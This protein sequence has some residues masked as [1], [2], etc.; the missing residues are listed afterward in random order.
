MIVKVCGM[1]DAD[2]IRQVAQ[3]GIHMMGFIFYQK[4]PRCVSRPVSRCEADAGV[5]RIGVFVNDSVMHILQCINDYNLNGVQ[6]HGQETPEFGRQLKANGV[7]LLLKA[8]S[9]A[10]VNDLKQCGAYDGIVDYFVFDTKTPDYGGSGKCFDWEVLRHYKGT[11]PFLLSGGLGMHNTEELLRFQH[12][13]WCG[14]DLNSCFEVAPGHKDVA[15][16]KQY[17]QTVREIL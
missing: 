2:N 4:S 6:L 9:V 7:E 11:T 5:E 13:R 16:L 10:S 1:R 12:P 8:V 15:L 14:I 17:L 3:L